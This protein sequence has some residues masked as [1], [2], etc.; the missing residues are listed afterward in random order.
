MKTTYSQ[1]IN[2]TEKSQKG[3]EGYYKEQLKSEDYRKHFDA[4]EL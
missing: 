2:L 3:I 4:I 1:Q